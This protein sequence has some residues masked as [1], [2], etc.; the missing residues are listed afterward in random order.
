MNV[1]DGNVLFLFIIKN[2]VNECWWGEFDR[3]Y[4]ISLMFVVVG[5][6]IFI[7]YISMLYFLIKVFDN[8]RRI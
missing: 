7:F 6:G 1:V 3:F 4:K 5:K 8:L 2:G